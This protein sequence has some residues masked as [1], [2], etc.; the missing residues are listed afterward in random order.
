[1]VVVLIKRQ[2]KF[3]R[4]LIT[5]KGLIKYFRKHNKYQLV[6][7]KCVL[8]LDLVLLLIIKKIILKF[9]NSSHLKFLYNKNNNKSKNPKFKE[10]KLKKWKFR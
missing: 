1:M 4:E 10:I 2:G 6:L 5:V 3:G 8:F 9:P 7:Y